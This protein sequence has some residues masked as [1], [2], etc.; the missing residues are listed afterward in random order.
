MRNQVL[1]NRYRIQERIGE[2]GMAFVYVAVDEKLGRRVA[3]KVL[4]EHMEKNQDIRKRFQMEAQAISS[5]DH[6]NIVKIYDFSGE[7]QGRL[8][9]VTEVIK[10]QNLAQYVQQFAGAWL[11]PIIAACVVREILKALNAAHTHGIVHRDVKPE[12]VM[13][14]T[15]GQLK[16]MDFGIAKDLGKSSMT[17][18]GT[19]MGSPSY[20]SPE[21]IRGRDVDLRSDLYSLS[22]LFYEIVTGRLPFVGQTT[23][24]VVLKIMEGEFSYPRFLVPGLP[25]QMDAMIVR[26]MSKD[27]AHRFQTANDYAYALDV[28][29]KNLGFDESHVELERYFKDPAR[30]D[31]RLKRTKF[32]AAVAAT[33]ARTSQRPLTQQLTQNR[34]QQT[35]RIS[36]G[37]QRQPT[38]PPPQRSNN[39]ST[40]PRKQAV[41]IPAPPPPRG[42]TTR[43]SP[44]PQ[45]VDLASAQPPRQQTQYQAA[46]LPTQIGQQPAAAYVAQA[47]AEPVAPRRQAGYAPQRVARQRRV[48]SVRVNRFT[49]VGQSWVN[50][51][52]GVALVGLIGIVSL[53][54]FIEL[55]NRLQARSRGGRLSTTTAKVTKGAT[56]NT[57]DKPGARRNPKIKNGTPVVIKQGLKKPV[58]D[59]V[60]GPSL[61]VETPK[62]VSNKLA[63]PK[64]PKPT[65]L[66]NAPIIVRAVPETE[67]A[68]P[69]L[70]IETVEL[71][72]LAKKD[73]G[74]A[75][76]VAPV[77]AATP[78]PSTASGTTTSG[79]TSAPP[80]DAP[81]TPR[82]K[83]EAADAPAPTPAK[84]GK[85]KL[86]VASDP[87]A[88]IYLDGRRVG[89]T[90]DN[91]QNSGWL[92][93]KSGKHRLELKR[94][95]YNTYRTSF[96]LAPDEARNLPRVNL[97]TAGSGMSSG[98]AS[99][100]PIAKGTA[101]TLRVSTFPAQVTIKN[102]D[103]NT[104]QAFT[105]KA[106]SRVIPLES[107]RY[108]IKV[109]RKGEVK[110]RELNLTGTQGQLTFTADFKGE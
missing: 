107:G 103:D 106:A 42:N 109:E 71:K 9:I 31:E 45:R 82:D 35:H 74:A 40:V 99:Q 39:Q 75:P 34:V 61:F 104:S 14:T 17:L 29:L 18:T 26:G 37:G 23:H 38:P 60:A 97:E 92:D 11:H 12:N 2:G 30:Y 63:K 87:A 95:G 108:Q 51:I 25:D 58:N 78:A 55:S 13:M 10:G 52:F 19:F 28:F 56:S 73:E 20:M 50:Y 90:V 94:Q 101:L 16:L 68:D 76:T 91:T 70:S 6:P 1:G 98:S 53:W 77:A 83:S 47:V 41:E 21:Q 32:A 79:S 48:P 89:T 8:W 69:N 102:L 88:E 44:Q 15:D 86:T 59:L 96:E 66:S 93:V 110:E 80:A 33:Q 72:K 22:V 3:I 36:K 24:D 105:M 49:I 7:G 5:L 57:V 84:S 4:H 27:P 62:P 81:T 100:A 54:G 43:Q 67:A 65:K 64:K 85:A 46:R